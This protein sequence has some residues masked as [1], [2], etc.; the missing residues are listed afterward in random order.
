MA[1]LTPPQPAPS[2]SHSAKEILDLTKEA[3]EKER[4]LQ[5]KIAALPD[6]EATF[7][8]V[9]LA[10][11]HSE[12]EFDAV[13]EPL[14]FYQNVSP[15][16][17]LRDASNEAEVLVRD[18][19]VESSM[20][21]DVFNKKLAAQKNISQAGAT[22]TAEE[23]RLV[24]KMVLDGTRAGLALPE[25]ERTE[26]TELKKE[27]S[28]VCLEFSKNFNEENGS[29]TF[30]RDELKGVPEDVISGYNTH[31]KDGQEVFDVT[32][33][34]PDIFPVFKNAD[35][36]ETR[37]RAHESYEARLAQNAPLLE[38]AL[39]LRRKIAALL[40]YPTWA[41][42][43][44]EVKMVKSAS[45]VDEFLKDLEQKLRPLGVKERETLLGLKAADHAAANPETPF[46]GQFYVWDYR[47]YDRKYI[48]K[49]LALDDAVVKEF[50]PVSV[51]V[52]TILEIYQTLLSV[53]FEEIKDGSKWHP[54]AQMFAVWEADAKD[55]SGFVGYCYLDLFP[56]A[57][58]Y[59]HAAV[60]GLLPGYDLPA[61]KRSY[62]L[63]AMVANLAK[64]TAERP[65]LMPHNDVVTFFHEMGHVFHGLLS[66]TRFA[67]FHGT[68]VARDFVE[69]PSQMLE[70]W[71]WE[72]TVLEKM[73][74]HYKTKESLPAD[75]IDKI[76]KS[77]YVNV[78][79]F[80][81]RQL[82]FAQFD[83]KVHTAKD[84]EDYTALWNDLRES[85]S[86]VKGGTPGPG[87]GTFAH[88][89]GG[90]DAGYYGYSYSL[91]Y[92]AD[93]YHTVFKKDPLDPKLGW[94]YRDSIL[95]PGGSREE[96]DSLK[97]FLGR[98]A[99][100]EAFMRELFGSSTGTTAN[101]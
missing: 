79:L 70:N 36:S 45:N 75:L 66:R 55:E 24:E 30:T 68:A 61:G 77:R 80:Y 76:V 84:A 8:S 97:E 17:A 69:A 86:L 1:S 100:S 48:E 40:G 5:D 13:A 50:F 56:R 67:R 34:T 87:Q 7:E 41:D 99:N 33:K 23:A 94:R 21:I 32:H 19:G 18:F 90:Y 93:M 46:D 72:P 27:L 16:K 101:L 47:Y 38:R 60:W 85:I 25:K 20:R 92:A 63:T 78:G 12:A 4:T 37:R 53:R 71:C 83:L 65:A 51:V 10:L 31:K 95:L 62:P 49:T 9:F 35:S 22:L 52:P 57:S 73:S 43:V 59:G 11:A 42:Y 88:I 3:I 91:V 64:P 44:T 58:K 26:L 54:D 96:H 74:S 89:V 14:S 15:D 39:D 28:Q 6:E 2:W 98:P 81:L 82:F 29:I